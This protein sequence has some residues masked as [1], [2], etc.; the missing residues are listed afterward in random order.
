MVS[1]ELLRRYSF[2]SSLDQAQQKAIALIA[3]V[4]QF[5]KGATIFEEG[6][7]AEL[8]YVLLE[9]CVDL[10]YPTGRDPAEH[11]LVAEINIGEPFSISALIEP[12]MLTATAKATAPSRILK[13]EGKALRALCE[14]DPHLGFALM[15]QAARSAMERLH[16]A[17]VQIA[18]AAA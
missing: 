6:Q 8:F 16:F 12:H 17:R 3:D 4:L 11:L 1:P 15:E 9:G 18:A 5:D 2:F 10:Y 13:I 7:P 14:L